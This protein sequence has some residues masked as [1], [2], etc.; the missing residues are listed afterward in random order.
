MHRPQDGKAGFP[1]WLDLTICDLEVLCHVVAVN[2]FSQDWQQLHILR[3]TDSEPCFFLLKNGRSREQIRLEIARHVAADALF[4]W[5]SLKHRELFYKE[6]S[7][8][9]LT[10][11]KIP[12]TQ[13]LFKF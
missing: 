11:V 7:H 8:R 2:I 1:G 9:K 5:S 13:D 10:P 3:E 6:C 12:L 4:R